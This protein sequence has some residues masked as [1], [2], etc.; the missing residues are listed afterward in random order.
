MR[1]SEKSKVRVVTGVLDIDGLIMV[2]QGSSQA[3]IS[4]S[5]TFESRRAGAL[6]GVDEVVADAV[7]LARPGE[8]LVEVVV[9][10]VAGEPGPAVALVRAGSV[11]TDAV[12][13]KV[14]GDGAFVDVVGAVG[15]GPAAGAGTLEPVGLVSTGGAIQT[16]AEE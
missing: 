5:L 16:R 15:T 12:V 11:P 3:L 7:V 14:F 4:R 6:V 1:F 8:T 9:A 13:A 2:N 10:V